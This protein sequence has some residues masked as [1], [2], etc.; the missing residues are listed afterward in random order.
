MDKAIL[1]VR[2]ANLEQVNNGLSRAKLLIANP[3]KNR[4]KF[5]IPKEVFD[6]AIPS[7]LGVPVVAHFFSD[8]QLGGHEQDIINLNGELRRTGKTYAY[9]FVDYVN[10]PYWE[11]I[12]DKEWLCATVYIFTER[13]PESA[14]ILSANQSMEVKLSIMDVDNDGY[15][16]VNGMEFL[17]VCALNPEGISPTFLDSKFQRFSMD[18][19]NKDVE[20]M[21]NL[22]EDFAKGESKSTPSKPSE[23]IKGSDKNK[24]GSASTKGSNITLNDSI[25]KSLENK[26]KEHNDSVDNEKSKK[27]TLGDLKKVYRRGAGA[28]ST[29]HRP[30]VSSRNQWAMGRVN[31]YL[32]LLKNGKPKDKDYTTDN[33]LLP[34]GHPKKS[35]MSFSYDEFLDFIDEMYD[36]DYE[37]FSSEF[38]A[39]IEEVYNESFADEKTNFPKKGDNQKVSLRN[40][41]YPLFDKEY[42]KNL[43]EK[44]P[45][46][47]KKGGNILGNTQYS[48]LTKILEQ[49]GEVKT[50]TDEKAIRLREAWMARHYKDHRIAGVVAQIKWLGIGS[51]G[52]KYMKDL[53]KEEKKKVDMSYTLEGGEK[54]IE[55]SSINF[56]EYTA[57]TIDE[58]NFAVPKG[59]GDSIEM[60]T[61][62]ENAIDGKVGS[63]NVAELK[64]KIFNAKNYKT[65]IKKAFLVYPSNIDENTNTG[66]VKYPVVYFKDGKLYYHLG[67]IKA[68]SSRLEQNKEAPYYNEAKSRLVK[69]R[70]AVGM[71]EEFSK[72]VF[73]MNGEMMQ[74]LAMAMYDYAMGRYVPY[75]YDDKMVYAMDMDENKPVKM[76][77][78]MKEDSPEMDMEN[79]AYDM[80]EMAYD[81]KDYENMMRALGTMKMMLKDKYE[82]MN[83]YAMMEKDYGM[84]K[85]NY[86]KLEK[87]HEDT[88]A[89]LEEFSDLSGKESEA[90]TQL[91]ELK[92]SVESKDSEISK[93]KEE[94]EKF[95]TELSEMKLEKKKADAESILAKN[96]FSYLSDEDK[97]ELMKE[98][99]DLSI[100]TFTMKAES[101]ALR[102]V[103]ASNAFNSR[104]QQ[105][106]SYMGR[107][108]TVVT[109]DNKEESKDIFDKIENN[110]ED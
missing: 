38:D 110:L 66:D 70:K 39:S 104:E 90:L 103:L 44:Y 6:N 68:A 25:V 94:N 30:N 35:N 53:I 102:K 17:A 71:T 26:V 79:M 99:S 1:E 56:S 45:S 42:A 93:L 34:K 83:E 74:K 9:G 65:L 21:K 91:I 23:K 20:Y 14:K 89:K 54:V 37:Y 31:A 80:E 97:E 85:E 63:K 96:E 59:E 82:K 5:N 51:R 105:S 24:D 67:F 98:I 10:L 47:W 92:A 64:R 107:R 19:I 55:F 40:S 43:K 12:D 41:K 13:F 101:K 46:I 109:D 8:G 15:A 50:S 86:S 57:E 2:F 62:K 7:L 49:N 18:E 72:E 28:Y 4:K 69:V 106:F 81:Y 60:D 3:D 16:N 52:E 76:P 95:S 36:G 100:E 11:I 77:Y 87:E 48:R 73:A 33:D 32:Y 61:S 27:A 22:I 88:K 29:S 78:A 108:T 84:M 75:A 58:V